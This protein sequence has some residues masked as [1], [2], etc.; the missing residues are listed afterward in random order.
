MR[1]AWKLALP[2]LLALLSAAAPSRAA[3][4]GAQERASDAA[5]HTDAATASRFSRDQWGLDETEW[6]RYQAL[7]TGIRGSISPPALSPVEAL[8]IH[9]R[10]DAERDQY[11][12]QFAQIMREDTERVLA[13]QRAYDKAWKDLNP[14]GLIADPSRLPAQTPK[15]GRSQPGDRL[16][17][18]VRPGGCAAC[19]TF[20]AA[21]LQGR[22]EGARLDIYFVGEAAD[23]A[24]RQWAKSRAIDP[25]DVR[26][27]RVTLNHERGELAQA[28]PGAEPPAL[29]R[30]RGGVAT[31]LQAQ[32]NP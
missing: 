16:L 10:T 8:G 12:K 6:K 26:D 11:A 21:G 32:G 3:E 28:A 31:R 22:R 25:G 15:P 17:L 13:F 24:I 2:A 29:V 18:F 27:R 7:M 14:T 9:A 1:M 5:P 23:D 30:V 19:D 4:T 20:L